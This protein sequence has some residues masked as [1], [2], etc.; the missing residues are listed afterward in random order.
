MPVLM[1]YGIPDDKAGVAEKMIDRL[2]YAVI[3]IAELELKLDEIS[4]FCPRDLVQKGLGEEVIVF[5]EGLFD[6]PER[7]A[8]V[9]QNLAAAVVGVMRSYFPFVSLVE[10]F[11]RPFD[12]ESGFASSAG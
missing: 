8:V 1:V 7:T 11:V 12:P 5:V 4:V 2:R 6:K 3:G 10:C 9:R